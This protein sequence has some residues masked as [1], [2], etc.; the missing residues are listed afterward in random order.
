MAYHQSK[1]CNRIVSGQ[2]GKRESHPA[3]LWTIIEKDNIGTLFVTY[4]CLGREHYDA[5]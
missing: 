5:R 4:C 2:M 3:H 1:K